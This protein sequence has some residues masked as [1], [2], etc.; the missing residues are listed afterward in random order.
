M[1]AASL[2][3]ITVASFKA[4]DRTALLKLLPHAIVYDRG[5]AFRP[6]Q[7]D[8]KRERVADRELDSWRVIPV[9]V[10]IAVGGGGGKRQK[11]NYNFNMLCVQMSVRGSLAFNVEHE[12][13]SWCLE[14]VRVCVCV[15]VAASVSDCLLVYFDL[16]PQNGFQLVYVC[17]CVCSSVT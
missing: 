13:S 15:Y 16:S 5:K 17:I 11:S 7:A 1:P 14:F 9:V 4:S 2:C 12:L 6:C 8:S 3:R 10:A